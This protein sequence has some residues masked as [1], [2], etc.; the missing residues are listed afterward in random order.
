[1]T[2]DL[3]SLKCECGGDIV[4]SSPCVRQKIDIPEIVPHVTDYHLARGRCKVCRKRKSGSLPPNVTSDLFGPRIKAAIGSLSGFYK[5][6]KREVE[7]ILKDLFNV[8]ISLGT[9]SN[10]ESR[11]TNKCNAAYEDIELE[12]SYSPLVH[13]DETSHYKKGKLGW[14][15]G[16]FSKGASLIKLESS[17]GKKVLE[18]SIFSPGDSII[19]SDRYGAYNY[20]DESNR[21]LCWSHL[22][23]DFERFAHSEHK[24]VRVMGEYLKK[25]SSELFALKEYLL[26]ERI[27]VLRFLS[28]A[29][30]LRKRAWSYL[31]DIVDLEGAVHASRVA[32]NIMKS[33]NMMWRFL[34]SPQDIPLT[35]NHAEQQIRHYVTYRKNSYFTQSESGD[36]FLERVISLY[37][38]WK[39]REQNP[40]QN[41]QNILLA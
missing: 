21:Q 28:R 13:M 35:N 33:E 23:R 39:K 2:I 14:C 34:E 36:R 30:R 8:N 18:N 25:M 20:F 7:S 11:I 17:R 5:N 26:E 1:M 27:D 38:T 15:W 6:S 37:L 9:I 32:R 29:R 4:L 31:R 10:N 3:D 40:V 22:A 24:E 41:L 12:L 16:F 19:V